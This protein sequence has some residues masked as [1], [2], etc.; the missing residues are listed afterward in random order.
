M[1]KKQIVSRISGCSDLNDTWT[2]GASEA[3]V[4]TDEKTNDQITDNVIVSP[5]YQLDSDG[6]AILSDGTPVV[7]PMPVEVKH[8]SPQRAVK[9]ENNAPRIVRL[10][11]PGVLDLVKCT[12][13][14]T[15]LHLSGSPLRM[16]PA[17]KV[18]VCK[19]CKRFYTDQNF[20][21]DSS[22][23]DENCRWCADGGDLICCDACPN[24]FCKRCIKRNLGRSALYNIESLEDTDTWKCL[25]CDPSPILSLQK[26]CSDAIQKMNEF[27]INKKRRSESRHEALKARGNRS[28]NLQSGPDLPENAKSTQSVGSQPSALAA[29][30]PGH[31]Q[32]LSNVFSQLS[33]ST[34]QQTPSEPI[35]P[36]RLTDV[37]KLIS[38]TLCPP[39]NTLPTGPSSSVPLSELTSSSTV[40]PVPTGRP[41]NLANS[42]ISRTAVVVPSV[43]PQPSS[44]LSKHQNSSFDVAAILNQIVSVNS[45]NV[46][47]AL[48]ATRRCI[49]TFS[50]DIHRLEIKIAEASN[51]S[52]IASVVRSFQSIYRFHLFARL[53]N[54]SARMREEVPRMLDASSTT[55]GLSSQSVDQRAIS[56]PYCMNQF[57]STSVT[58]D[59]TNDG[60]PNSPVQ[61][62][63]LY[64][65]INSVHSKIHTNAN[66]QNLPECHP[67]ISSEQRNKSNEPDDLEKICSSSVLNTDTSNR[68][69]QKRCEGS[70][71]AEII[72]T[73]PRKVR[74]R[75]DMQTPANI[76]PPVDANEPGTEELSEITLANHSNTDESNAQKQQMVFAED[77]SLIDRK[78]AAL[79][80]P[81]STDKD[82][83]LEPATS[84]SETNQ[85]DTFHSP[86]S[87]SSVA[88]A[89][90]EDDDID[91]KLD[92]LA[93]IAETSLPGAD[94]SPIQ[95]SK[96]AARVN[97]SHG[98]RPRDSVDERLV[99]KGHSI[100]ASSVFLEDIRNHIGDTSV[101]HLNH[102]SQHCLS[103]TVINQ[104]HEASQSECDNT[105]SWWVWKVEHNAK[106]TI[107]SASENDSESELNKLSAKVA[108]LERACDSLQK[109]T[110]ER[111]TVKTI[112]SEDKIHFGKPS[113]SQKP[114]KQR[115][116]LLSD[117]D[118]DDWSIEESLGDDF[119]KDDP[120]HVQKSEPEIRATDAQIVT[121]SD[122]SL[123]L[124]KE[125]LRSALLAE[126]ES[127][128]ITNLDYRNQLLRSSS[129]DS[130]EEP[131]HPVA[132]RHQTE[133]RTV[134]ETRDVLSQ[135][136]MN[137]SD[138]VELSNSSKYT[139]EL[140]KLMKP[141]VSL[142]GSAPDKRKIN[143]VTDEGDLPPNIK[144]SSLESDDTR[145]QHL[146]PNRVK[147]TV[148][149]G[150]CRFPN[151][152]PDSDLTSSE[153]SELE[154]VRRNRK[155]LK[156][157]QTSSD[158][159]K[160]ECRPGDSDSSE[161]LEDVRV[162]RKNC[163]K[164]QFGCLNTTSESSDPEKTIVKKS[165]ARQSARSRPRN[166]ARV[167]QKSELEDAAD[168]SPDGK[169]VNVKASQTD[170]DGSVG[171]IK[172]R[173]R[174]RKI[175]NDSN[176]SKT[177]KTAEAQERERRRRIAE[178]QKEYNDCILQEG[179]GINVVTKMLVL[180]K[181]TD[182]SAPS[183]QVHSDI[184][185]HLKPHQV[186]AVRFLWDCVIESVERQQK[187]P[188]ELMGGAIL[189]HCMGLGKTLSVIAFIHTLIVHADVLNIRR[190]L[191]ICPVNTLL[192]WK[193]E[194]EMWLPA[195]DQIDVFEL[196]SKADFKYRVDVLK[197]WFR[198]GGVM[199]IGYDMFRNFINTRGR[200]RGNKFSKESITEAL[201]DPGPDIVI[202]DEGH[203]LK[204][205]K[206][207]LSKAISQIRTRRRVIL[208]GTP[209]QNN[210]SEYHAMVN[211]VKP[212]LLGT[213]REFNNRFANPIR[214]GQHSNS[215]ERDV[216]FM[217][218][219]AHVLYK[220]LDGCVQ[221]KDYNSLTQYLPPR[222]EYVIMC[223][224]STIQGNLYR[225]Y[226]K[227]RADRIAARTEQ[228]ID[229]GGADR[230]K[231]LFCDQQTLYR[232]WTHPFLLRSHET[233]QARK[234][235]LEDDEEITGSEL[236]LGSTSE[237]EEE[238]S[239]TSD[240]SDS[241]ECGLTV[242]P[243]GA[244]RTS[245]TRR[246][247]HAR[248]CKVE[249]AGDRD[250]VLIDS[251]S[252][253]D[254][255]QLQT[256]GNIEEGANS[257][258]AGK[259][260]IDPWWY[261][262][263]KEE[264]D[265]SLEV[266]GKL[267]VLFRLLK[268]CND[269]GDKV[270]IFSQSLLSLDL[271]ERFLGELHRQWLVSQGEA[272]DKLPEGE[273]CPRSDLSA[274]FSELGENTW[275]RGH[276]YERMDGS[277]N[278]VVRKGLQHRFNRRANTRLRLFLISTRAGGLGINLVAANRLI[279]F[280][281]S[282][283]PSHDIQSIFR[284]YR[285][286]QTKP[287]YIYRLIA[288]GT[289]EEKIYDRQVTKQSLSLRVIDEQQIDRHFTNADL[290]ALYTFD[291]DVW[292]PV[293]AAKRPTPK[294]PK[295]RLLADMLSEFPHLIVNYHDHDSLLEHRQDEGLTE[296]E[297]QEAWREY[298]EEKT[299]GMSLAQHQRLMQ[300]QELMAQA[301]AFRNLQQQQ[302][303]LM[304]ARP[305]LNV[306]QRAPYPPNTL[307][308]L[309]QNSNPF[310]MGPVQPKIP[311]ESATSQSFQLLAPP[312]QPSGFPYAQLFEKYRTHI[313]QTRPNLA[314]D[315][316]QLD[317]VVLSHM[318]DLM[319]REVRVN[320]P[321]PVTSFSTGPP[322]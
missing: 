80:L 151:D 171:E 244:E 217:K 106:D 190:C 189:A 269:I 26:E 260:N 153:S 175:Y 182:G 158:A 308:N 306:P 99:K 279:V 184:L 124:A 289:M 37:F 87:S 257:V 261:R 60:A 43:L 186:D 119:P 170:S 103:S 300:Q 64:S 6:R 164:S 17:L 154:N 54:L 91:W 10:F 65:D 298:E 253:Y 45:G 321:M 248:S 183:I 237:A 272:L 180:E 47:A 202:C 242:N 36:S 233:R 29:V 22:G 132:C 28:T 152:D 109:R 82:T 255:N 72:R 236:G 114:N 228:R 193:H 225:A 70:S 98:S 317:K 291:P 229:D 168:K 176:I 234:M 215:T 218:K 76:T 2:L 147:K 159:S 50:A 250:V 262:D 112:H 40:S 23:K 227:I 294:L 273:M 178:K 297:R 3:T 46:R 196:A 256:D 177:T 221:R 138:T 235:L 56:Q 240:S 68:T 285:F 63:A 116:K 161:V 30:Q 263:Y 140:R 194:W 293:E 303:Q 31:F 275:V 163:R 136:E 104:M 309:A 185:K 69:G 1:R 191:V 79:N 307:N 286:G 95:G 52:E 42:L 238:I 216:N 169:T 301:Q 135:D 142:D 97:S 270:L 318:M 128:Y 93:S 304:A 213:F 231:T 200:K 24:A 48:K 12:V 11:N 66:E 105:R 319:M 211:F 209:L 187:S 207:G 271:L 232:V 203:I 123:C 78:P 122:K 61:T 254:T 92:V 58:I 243:T 230:R 14:A 173:K 313:L 322:T 181:S 160:P 18:I 74:K 89:E 281:A 108:S 86:L 258:P 102:A 201:L 314:A 265:W 290:Q 249:S 292:D 179:A 149:T 84:Q 320:T 241:N 195:N 25:V 90:N 302:Q 295:D 148:Q 111:E 226:L 276:D 296:A 259:S 246:R 268:K 4:N 126:A 19:R 85:A 117:L 214:N 44:T 247:R 94:D 267:E 83:P 172:S 7:E 13:C 96:E 57:P 130:T 67:A 264:Y 204:N 88:M 100:Q 34:A 278:A 71:S 311:V 223:R 49:D 188:N 239:A 101:V 143:S 134:S 107:A 312:R 251:D 274:Y 121:T 305:L 120:V 59:L 266:G 38:Q 199:L 299:L 155:R 282:W 33:Q 224:L 162:R 81:C 32:A 133:S 280:D 9:R 129:D 8:N 192:N 287:V 166:R 15:R 150:N 284:S 20:V 212:N 62:T 115:K 27:Y 315:P 165:A 219:R 245:V 141:V 131:E 35:P 197:H 41:T 205:D 75:S 252:S 157:L 139:G 125:P 210:L 118:D 113:R 208:T 53:A 198:K 73:P 146:A 222:H 277:M 110:R 310:P 174:I 127:E 145:N 77:A 316:A 137:D 16:H 220:T 55:L 206:S 5:V 51:S 283:N 167:R 288:Q 21:Q 144:R 39:L 156:P